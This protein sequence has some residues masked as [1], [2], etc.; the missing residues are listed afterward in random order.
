MRVLP[1]AVVLITLSSLTGCTSES[2]HKSVP[3]DFTDEPAL[4]PEEQ[5]NDSLNA[6]PG[7][8]PFVLN[9]AVASSDSIALY[10][11]ASEIN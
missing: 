6:G 1:F 10:P 3:R 7:Q 11:P 5:N 4:Y 8:V 9:G 2:A